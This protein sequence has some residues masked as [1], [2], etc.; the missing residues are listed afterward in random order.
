MHVVTCEKEEVLEGFQVNPPDNDI[1][2]DSESRHSLAL[3]MMLF[4]DP[5]LLSNIGAHLARTHRPRT[6]ARIHPKMSLLLM[7]IEKRTRDLV[8]AA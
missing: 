7:V 8:R 6:V 4:Q 5:A 2:V 1:A 3:S